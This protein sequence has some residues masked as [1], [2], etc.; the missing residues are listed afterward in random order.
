MDWNEFD[1]HIL[2]LLKQQQERPE[3]IFNLQSTLPFELFKANWEQVV[4][5]VDYKLVDVDIDNDNTGLFNSL[6]VSGRYPENPAI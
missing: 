1:H 6:I 2:A 5:W 4:V 3:L